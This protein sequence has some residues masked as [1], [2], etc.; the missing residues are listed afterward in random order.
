MNKD[1]VLRAIEEKENIRIIRIIKDLPV[2]ERRAY[3]QGYAEGM[4]YQA[5]EDKYLTSKPA[6]RRQ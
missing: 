2:L 4:L 1:L 3:L 6:S 5:F